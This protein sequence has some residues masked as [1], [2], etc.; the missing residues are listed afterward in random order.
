M[1][2]AHLVQFTNP[3]VPATV[4][5]TRHAPGA[6]PGREDV[7]EA[8]RVSP[9]AIVEQLSSVLRTGFSERDLSHDMCGWPFFSAPQQRLGK[10]PTRHEDSAPIPR[11]FLQPL[12]DCAA[13]ADETTFPLSVPEYGTDDW[14]LKVWPSQICCPADEIFGNPDQSL[15]PS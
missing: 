3:P 12:T 9:V 11:V 5:P 2:A 1:P 13:H 8:P 6:S 4:S 14:K 10:F 7:C 15:R